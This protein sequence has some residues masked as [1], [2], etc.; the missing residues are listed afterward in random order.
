AGAGAP[1]RDDGHHPHARRVGATA[2]RGG[3]P[4]GQRE[5]ERGGTAARHRPPAPVQEDREV[6]AVAAWPTSAAYLFAGPA[7]SPI[8]PRRMAERAIASVTPSASTR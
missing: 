3:P 5:Q 6:R 7:A 8:D 4:P 1:P 2:R